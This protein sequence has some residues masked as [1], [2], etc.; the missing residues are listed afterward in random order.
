MSFGE[1]L[2][3]L[4]GRILKSLAGIVL[5]FVAGLFFQER[6]IAIL[7]NPHERAMR[8]LEAGLEADDPRRYAGPHGWRSA[9][10]DVARIYD[11]ERALR[12]APED[13]AERAG[14]VRTH[15][16]IR[17]FLESEELGSATLVATRYP[18]AFLTGIKAA[19]VLAL[20]LGAPW[21]LYQLWLFV[22]AGLY[23]HERKYVRL[24]LP[25]SL[26]LFLT[27]AVFGYLVLIPFGLYF[28]GGWSA[29]HVATM[30]TLADYF[31]LF[32]TLTFAL[33]VIFQLP[34]AMIALTLMGVATPRTFT[35]KRRYFILAAFVFGAILTP[36]DPVTQ[37]LMAG[38]MLVLY[39]LGVVG[40]RLVERAT[41]RAAA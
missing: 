21:T 38:P 9:L 11:L 3:E 17:K 25:S 13:P 33:G 34:L 28:L 26:L 24:L 6:L 32:L 1:H 15:G 5:L 10:R 23:P 40:A 29:V 7:A 19:L 37:L 20:L 36:P 2:E 39:E 27:G 35:E 31:S 4:R 18:E 41:R 22:A 8:Q 16:A 14:F 12:P 30:I